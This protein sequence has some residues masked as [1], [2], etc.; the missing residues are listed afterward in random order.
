MHPLNGMR[1]KSVFII[2][3]T[4][5]PWIRTAVHV[6][7]LPDPVINNVV[8][9]TCAVFYLLLQFVYPRKTIHSPMREAVKIL[10]LFW[11]VMQSLNMVS[12]SIHIYLYFLS[13]VFLN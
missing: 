7:K 13:F 8:L 2:L 11:L 1:G 6:F 5:D 12:A 10:A 9:F 3:A 4:K